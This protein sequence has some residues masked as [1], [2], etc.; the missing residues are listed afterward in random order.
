[1]Q[2][3]GVF[4]R[5]EGYRCFSSQHEEGNRPW[6]KVKKPWSILGDEQPSCE[7]RSGEGALTCYKID[8]LAS[9]SSY[10]FVDISSGFIVAE[11]RRFSLV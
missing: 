3:F 7:V 9:K 1:M 2:K 6:F 4:G 8:G 11:V 5:W 10:K